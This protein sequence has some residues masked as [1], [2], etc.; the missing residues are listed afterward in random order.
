M[1]TLSVELQCHLPQQEE[2]LLSSLH[3]SLTLAI[4]HNSEADIWGYITWSTCLHKNIVA[5]LCSLLSAN[6]LTLRKL[7][8]FLVL[9]PSRPLSSAHQWSFSP[10]LSARGNSLVLVASQ[11]LQKLTNEHN[12]VIKLWHI[13]IP[14]QSQGQEAS[15]HKLILVE[16]PGTGPRGCVHYCVDEPQCLRLH[17]HGNR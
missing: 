10:T 17:H 14:V 15:V 12:F 7:G 9:V 16:H 13:M 8:F 2:Q 5:S 1:V 3:V 6:L 4:R 11:C